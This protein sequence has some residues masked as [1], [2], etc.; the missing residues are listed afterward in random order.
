MLTEDKKNAVAIFAPSANLAASAKS[1]LR[2]GSPTH[3]LA[4]GAFR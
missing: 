4:F 3:L 1:T 2:A